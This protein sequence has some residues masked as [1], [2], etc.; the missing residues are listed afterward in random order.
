HTFICGLLLF[1]V[2]GSVDIQTPGIDVVL[3]HTKKQLPGELSGILTMDSVTSGGRA[4]GG[5]DFYR[6]L[7]SLLV[8]LLSNIPKTEHAPQDMQLLA[9]SLIEVGNG[10]K[11]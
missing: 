3:I 5:F 2:D 4:W 8:F 10:V 6:L 11:A 9:L 1:G 7:S